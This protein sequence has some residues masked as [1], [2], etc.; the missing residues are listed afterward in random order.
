MLVEIMRFLEPLGE[1][2]GFFWFCLIL[3]GCVLLWRKQWI[4][5]AVLFIFA[6]FLTLLGSEMVADHLMVS[7]ERPYAGKALTVLPPADAV[8]LLG[9]ANGISKYEVFGIGFGEG[10]DRAI[11]AME[12]MRQNKAKRLIMGGGPMKVQGQQL[13][14]APRQHEWVQAW[15]LVRGQVYYL[16]NCANTREEALGVKALAQK[17]GWKNFLLVTSAYHMRRSESVFRTAGLNVTPVPCDYQVLGVP[18]KDRLWNPVPRYNAL[19]RLTLYIHEIIGGL[20][21]RIHG[22]I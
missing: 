16:T 11:T 12:L 7:L 15:G 18:R 2:L 1:P 22:W 5:A 3:V 4:G 21:Y 10:A 13:E 17:E 9:G 20:A 19:H 14:S 6:V 8:V